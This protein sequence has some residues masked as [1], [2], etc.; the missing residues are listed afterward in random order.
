MTFG[1]LLIL[2]LQSI[3]S[4]IYCV[5]ILAPLTWLFTRFFSFKVYGKENLDNLKPPV[6]MVSNHLT[7]IDSVFIGFAVG[8]PKLYWKPW[9]MTWHLPEATNYFR[10]LLAP[11]MW[12]SR[13]IPIVRGVPPKK[14]KLAKDKVLSVL[15]SKEMIHI[16]P[17]G[18]RSRTGKM[19]NNTTGI[20]RIYLGSKDCLVLPVYIRGT[21]NV[22]PI[23]CKLPKLFKKID[24]VIGEPRKLSSEHTGIRAGVD[25]SQQIFD[26]LKSMEDAYFKNS[27]YRAKQILQEAEAS[28]DI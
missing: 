6:I 3:F 27:E 12:L 1:K 20:G 16:F 28:C 10:G 14:Q 2:R 13:A 18:T 15:K 26:M 9:M 25:I 22:L 23:N 17:E 21:E 11:F 7:L 5:F 4:W 19:E 8:C 24:I